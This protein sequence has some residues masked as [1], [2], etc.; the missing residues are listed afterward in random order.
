MLLPDFRLA[1]THRLSQANI[2]FAPVLV[3]RSIWALTGLAIQSSKGQ[4]VR[5]QERVCPLHRQ[6]MGPASVS[7]R[8]D[9]V[10]LVRCLP[11]PQEESLWPAP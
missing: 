10:L 5:R 11:A 9:A 7:S 2:V 3:K 1:L 4:T 6:M 8:G